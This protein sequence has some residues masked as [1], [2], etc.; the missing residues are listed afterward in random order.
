MDDS[1]RR[2]LTRTAVAA[3]ASLALCASGVA[4]QGGAAAVD[5]AS[6]RNADAPASVGDWQ[7]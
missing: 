6:M 1:L 3:A 4:A 5:G 7:S 2:R